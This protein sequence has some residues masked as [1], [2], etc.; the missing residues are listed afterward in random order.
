[1][2]AVSKYI[3][4]LLNLVLKIQIAVNKINY[5]LSVTRAGILNPV[6]CSPHNKY[7]LRADMQTDMS[8]AVG[9]KSFCLTKFLR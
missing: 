4:L 6:R 5:L 7:Y 1:M 8:Y 3:A 9:S 2:T